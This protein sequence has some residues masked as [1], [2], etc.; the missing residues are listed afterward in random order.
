M[1][2][3]VTT[4]EYNGVYII[5]YIF[6]IHTCAHLDT[7]NI[8]LKYLYIYSELSIVYMHGYTIL[9]IHGGYNIHYSES[10]MGYSIH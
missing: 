8:N 4:A 1:S 7:L 9:G 6:L 2:G 10:C 5:V 3:I